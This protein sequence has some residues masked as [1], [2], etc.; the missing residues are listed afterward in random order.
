[1]KIGMMSAW[2]TDSGVSIHAEAVGKVWREMGHELSV[3]TF[4]RE[5]FHGEG[6]TGADEDYVIRCLGTQ[7]TNFL[8]PRPILTAPLDIL[9]VQ[10]VNML[11]AENLA[12]IFS[13]M[14][15]K[16]K[17]VHIVHE[18]TLPEEVGFYQFDWDGVS[19]FCH[20]QNFLNGI[21]P[22]A[23]LIHFPCFPLRSKDKREARKRLEMF[24]YPVDFPPQSPPP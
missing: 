11:P 22:E 8:D 9:V 17:T 1:M 21:Y 2:N 18:K 24:P 6:F 7:Q 4:I 19:Y 20:R 10:D 15:K 14:R 3:F 23:K 13:L 5:D 16:A 12:K